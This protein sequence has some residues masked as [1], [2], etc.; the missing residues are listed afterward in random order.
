VQLEV[1]KDP[2]GQA[3][4]AMKDFQNPEGWNVLPEARKKVPAVKFNDV[5][6]F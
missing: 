5:V 3:A 4:Q 6:P 2:P 1:Q